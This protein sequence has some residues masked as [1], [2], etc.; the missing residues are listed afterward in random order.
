MTRSSI[1]EQWRECVTIAAAAVLLVL[2]GYSLKFFPTLSS[3]YSHR[4]DFAWLAIKPAMRT[5]LLN[6]MATWQRPYFEAKQ[7]ANMLK[8]IN[9]TSYRKSVG[10]YPFLPNFSP[11]SLWVHRLRSTQIQSLNLS[12]NSLFK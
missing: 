7:S 2:A 11:T 3:S 1:G 9:R 4:I 5:L 12:F 10:L 8:Q 6:D